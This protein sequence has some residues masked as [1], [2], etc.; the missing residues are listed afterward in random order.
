[1]AEE[2]KGAMH[3]L[4]IGGVEIEID[5]SWIIVFALILWTLSAGYFPHVYPGRPVPAYCGGIDATILFFASV[6][7]QLAG[8]I[9]R[10]GIP[11]HVQMKASLTAPA[12][13]QP[14]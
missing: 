9:T 1:M 6:V 5:L 4:T 8:I 7:D 13:A 3:L 11:L 14:G 2:L 10:S 12:A